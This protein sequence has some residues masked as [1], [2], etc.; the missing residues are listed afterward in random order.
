MVA[1]LGQDDFVFTVRNVERRLAQ[2]RNLRSGQ[3][4][5]LNAQSGCFVC[6]EQG[7]IVAANAAFLAFLRIPPDRSVTGVAIV[8]FLPAVGDVLARVEGGGETVVLDGSGAGGEGPF[9]IQLAPNH[10]GSSRIEGVV[11]SLLPQTGGLPAPAP[12]GPAFG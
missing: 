1:L 12:P 10:Q 11:G 9:R 3:N 7:G 4:A 2:L 6:D 5:F 8:E